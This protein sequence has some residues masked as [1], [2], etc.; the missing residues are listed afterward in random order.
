MDSYKW[1]SRRLIVGQMSVLI[2]GCAAIPL[3]QSPSVPERFPP[4]EERSQAD[5]PVED[6][7]PA[8]A[9]APEVSALQPPGPAVV[10][11][12]DDA[13]ARERQ[14]DY[15]T[16]IAV[17]ERAVRIEPRNALVWHR[18]ARVNLQHGNAAQAEAMAKKSTQFAGNDQRLLA[19][20]WRLIASARRQRGDL[21]GAD[22]A[23]AQAV[24]LESPRR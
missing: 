24:I 5:V 13:A 9:P 2:S 11:L 7:G 23:D 20:N 6:R 1:F 18:L 16:S 3:S 4:V 19:A 15:D 17:L 8:V 12:L 21:K 14:G 10:A 22:A